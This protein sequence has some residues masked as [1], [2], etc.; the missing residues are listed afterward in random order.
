MRN[1]R[2][3][4]AR[5]ASP[6]RSHYRSDDKSIAMGLVTITRRGSRVLIAAPFNEDFRRE[7]KG[8]PGSSW[9]GN[10]QLWSVPETGIGELRDLIG[11]VYGPRWVPTWMQEWRRP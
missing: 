2:R 5:D 6:W 8:I 10:I 9:R 11:H 4:G 1:T 7:I 3:T